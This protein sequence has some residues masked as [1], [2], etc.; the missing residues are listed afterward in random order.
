LNALVPRTEVGSD[1]GAEAL[2]IGRGRHVVALQLT[3]R[4]ASFIFLN[5]QRY[6]LSEG[7]PRSLRNC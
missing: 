7:F 5:M 4:T 6:N 3:F 2:G 1:P